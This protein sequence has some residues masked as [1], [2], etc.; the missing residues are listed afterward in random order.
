LITSYE[1]FHFAKPNP[2]YYTEIL[3]R[4]GWPEG[5]VVM[6]GDDLQNDMEPARRVGLA[7][8][9]ISKN[10]NNPNAGPYGPS[11]VGDL[12]DFFP[13]IDASTQAELSPDLSQTESIIHTLRATPA[14]LA[15]HTADLS[16]THWKKHPVEGEWSLT[17]IVCHLRDVDHEVNLPRLEKVIQESNPFLAGMDTDPWAA[18]RQYEQQDGK[19]ALYDFT[20]YRM[21]I[22]ELIEHLSPADWDR[23]ARHAIF[24]PT[25]M[26]ELISILAG[27]DRLHLRQISTTLDMILKADDSGSQLEAASFYSR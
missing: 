24:G 8:F 10:G 5:P 27:H 11:A 19:S 25:Q 9:W 12:A 26:R 21:E 14:A 15:S 20:Q 22:L 4:L 6:V 7:T 2:A 17:E 3:A 18:K 13:W 16:L 1:T 23:P